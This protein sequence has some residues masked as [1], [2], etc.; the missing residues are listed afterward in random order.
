MAISNNAHL[1]WSSSN[2]TRS[3]WYRIQKP[4][5]A[6]QIPFK[7]SA[8]HMNNFFFGNYIHSKQF[9]E[10]EREPMKNKHETKTIVDGL[11]FKCIYFWKL[12]CGN[13]SDEFMAV[14]LLHSKTTILLWFRQI[15]VPLYY[16]YLVYL[17]FLFTDLAIICLCLIIFL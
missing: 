17:I 14:Y 7:H 4:R 11:K 12:Q 16:V 6:P 3:H 5:L 13:V 8:C 2:L 10:E 1:T 15:F 9:C